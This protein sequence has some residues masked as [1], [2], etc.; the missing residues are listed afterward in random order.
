MR[1]RF[2]PSPTGAMHLGNAWTAL[3]AWLQVRGQHGSMVL[4]I[5]DLD[6]E[7]SKG[8]FVTGLLA[9]LSWLGLNWDEGP[10]VGGQYVPY[11]Q[12]QRQE[13][14]AQALARL[15]QLDLVYPCY[16]TRAEIQ[17][18]VAAPNTGIA[19]RPYPGT[20]ARLTVQQQREKAYSGRR[21]AWR[22]RV[23]GGL[24]QWTDACQGQVQRELSALG[25]FI[26]R[27]ADGAYAYQLAVVVDDALMDLTHV[28]RGDDLLT[29]TAWQLYLYDVLG[30]RA[31][32]FAHVPLLLGRDG[33]RLAKR[34]GDVSIAALRSKGVRPE[35]IIGFLAYEAKLIPQ[36]FPVQAQELL[37]SL[38]VE[39]LPHDP[40]VVGEY[41]PY[42]K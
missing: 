24:V 10:D 2:A 42:K 28:L 9:D 29:S 15:K 35:E 23:P 39:N 5:E 32:Q 7:R 4:R 34:H 38:R 1:G 30:W 22:V 27:R 31:P 11:V 17:A 13:L 25:D 14:Y 36:F 41:L 21:P 18:A 12:S 33:H 37:G 26:I 6:P 8:G 3:L 16:C 19:E 40:I 20:C